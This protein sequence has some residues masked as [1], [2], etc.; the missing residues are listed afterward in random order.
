MN[1]S[2]QNTNHSTPGTAPPEVDLAIYVKGANKSFGV[3]KALNDVSFNANF[4]EIQA[5]IG[6]NGCGK[7]T[8]AKVLAG[9]LKVDSGEVSV[10]GHSPTTPAD[11][12]KMGVA[13]VFQEVMVA[14]EA[15]IAENL[16]AGADTL[17]AKAMSNREKIA[18][19]RVLMRELVGSDVDPQRLAAGLSLGVKAWITI[20]RALLSKPKILILDESSAALDFD[21][22]ERLFTKIR[23]LRDNGTAVLIVTHRIAEL[24]RICDRATVMRD[25]KNV[26]VLSKSEITEA[27][28]LGLMAGKTEARKKPEATAAK[29]LSGQ[30]VLKTSA[31]KVLPNADPV[32]F[33]LR[34]GEIIGVT[35]L[36]GQ[37]QDAFVRILAGVADAVESYPVAETGGAGSSA[38]IRGLESAKANGIEFVSGD[39]KREGILPNFSIFENLVTALYSKHRLGGKLN[40]INWPEL[41]NIFNWEVQRLSIKTGPRSNLIT[42]LSGGNQQKVLI[43]RAFALR[44]KVLVLNDP[45]RGIDVGTKR[46][47]YQHLKD[48]VAEGNS[49][50]YMSSELEEF[51][52]LCSRVAVFR[53]GSVFDTLTDGDVDPRL[54]LEAMFG[55]TRGA[56]SPTVPTKGNASPSVSSAARE[57]LPDAALPAAAAS[58]RVV[59]SNSE[60]PPNTPTLDPAGRAIKIRYF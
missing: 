20:G 57:K 1:A 60:P 25:G 6:G 13:M 49:V 28:L 22:T 50:V 5:I 21:S 27:N 26:G 48:F 9:V 35:G 55:Q 38:E 51:I 34:K 58:I 40:L 46:E 37:G 29:A 42:S 33:D 14:D 59:T 10:M 32:N 17:W 47:F 36:E 4:G 53:N 15:T 30:V 7:S 3:T 12:R 11:A 19:S 18:R 54:I 52:G 43:G 23:E 2:I 56:K 24:I 44:P 31:L 16:Y 39:R 8:M 41:E 45:A